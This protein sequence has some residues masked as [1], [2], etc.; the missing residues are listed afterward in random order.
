MKSATKTYLLRIHPLGID[1]TLG[2]YEPPKVVTDNKTG[3]TIY[4]CDIDQLR[5]IRNDIS[6]IILK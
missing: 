4:L 1:R 2:D 3:E 6:D 5:K